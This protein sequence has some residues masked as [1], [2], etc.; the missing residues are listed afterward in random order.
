MITMQL[1]QLPLGRR[2]RIDSVNWTAIP[3]SEAHRLRSLGIEEGA[4]IEALHRGI[5]FFRD[6]LAVRV[7]RMTIAMRSKVAA[8]INC[9][10]ID[11]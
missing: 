11:Q 3:D 7:G 10:V 5:L 6:P 2:A 1:D 9:A 4:A 8:S